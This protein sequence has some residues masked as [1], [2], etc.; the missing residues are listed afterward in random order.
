MTTPPDD[1]L[2]PVAATRSGRGGVAGAGVGDSPAL[3]CHASSLCSL[4]KWMKTS[5]NVVWLKE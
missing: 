2:A 3:S 4:A 5:S 1:R